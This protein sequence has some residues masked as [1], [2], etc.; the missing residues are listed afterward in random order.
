MNRSKELPL[1]LPINNSAFELFDS[2]F[3]VL[4]MYK[5]IAGIS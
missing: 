3:L 2:V 5:S 4:E 1:S